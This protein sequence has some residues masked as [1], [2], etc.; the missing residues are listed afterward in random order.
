MATGVVE[1]VRTGYHRLVFDLKTLSM[2]LVR[3]V[4]YILRDIGWLIE[5]FGVVLLWIVPVMLFAAAVVY[6][7]VQTVLLGAL[8]LVVFGISQLP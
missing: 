7:T 8:M 1:G 6:F 3:F 4:G 2:R 5:G